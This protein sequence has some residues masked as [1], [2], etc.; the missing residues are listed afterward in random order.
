MALTCRMEEPSQHQKR[1]LARLFDHLVGASEAFLQKRRWFEY[2]HP[3]W[4]YRHLLA[5][6]RVSSD[7]WPLLRTTKDPNEESFTKILA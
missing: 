1:T 2:C 6:L 7:P 5:G 3:A 4:G